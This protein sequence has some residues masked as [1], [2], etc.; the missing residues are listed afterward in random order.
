MGFYSFKIQLEI[1]FPCSQTHLG[2]GWVVFMFWAELIPNQSII[3]QSHIRMALLPQSCHL[4][5]NLTSTSMKWRPS[6]SHSINGAISGLR[7][8]LSSTQIMRAA[9]LA[10]SSKPFKAEHSGCYVKFSFLLPSLTF[11]LNLFGSLGT[12]IS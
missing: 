4:S 2:L 6:C 9:R 1:S 7:R 11:F 5:H 3:P 12:L 10:F 8:G